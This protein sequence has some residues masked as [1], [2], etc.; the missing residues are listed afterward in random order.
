MKARTL[1]VALLVSLLSSSLVYS[2]ETHK[3]DRT[4]GVSANKALADIVGSRVECQEGSADIYP[5]SGVDLMSFISVQTLNG[6]VGG[7]VSTN[8]IWGWEDP[9]TGVEY[10]LVGMNSGTSFVDVSDPTNP[11][12]IG[13]LPL[14]AGAF[15]SSWRDVKVY[16]NHAFIVADNS[17][18]HGMQVFDLTQLANVQNPPVEFEETAHYDR[19]ASA[20]N[21]VINEETGFAYVV[22]IGSG[23]TTCGGG[24]HMINIQDPTQ[25]AFEGCFAD[26]TT[27]RRGTG[28]SHDAQCVIYRGPDTEHVNKEICFG[29]NET[30]L[31]IAD[32]SDKANPERISVAEYPSVAYA[33]QGWLTEDHRYFYLDDEL[34]EPGTFANT[35]TIIFD[36]EDLDDPVVANTYFAETRT[37]D[38]NQY[39]VGD[40]LFQ[41]NYTSG[42]RI[43]DISDR[44]NPQEVALF[45]VLPS[46]QSYNFNGSWSNYPF[47]ESGNIIATSID[48][49]LF[50]VQP[51]NPLLTSSEEELPVRTILDAPYPNPFQSQ[52]QFTVQVEE[53]GHLEIEVFDLLG[54]KV[55]VLF[56]GT[57]QG[58]SPQQV[59]FDRGNLP[60]GEYIIRARGDGISIART[61]TIVK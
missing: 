53:S 4:E 39:V 54:R 42:L 33:H 46:D 2:Q 23:G 12:V 17:G 22:G 49:G 59:V 58:G 8:D 37:R 36:L 41:S 56:S 5:C 57:V 28:Y 15:A 20:H 45:D 31:S 13:H 50:V 40:Y 27:G 60:T 11:Q 61:V 44:V 30:A 38:H 14:H 16:N 47:F 52:T 25:P 48:E 35:R 21:I 32:V 7:A 18:N 10:A 26:N 1:F 34:D 19:F 24:L 43:L 55:G 9:G 29:S 6:G 3:G 51:A